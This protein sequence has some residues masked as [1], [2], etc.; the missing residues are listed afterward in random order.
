MIQKRHYYNNDNNNSNNNNNNY[1]NNNNNNSL[2][3]MLA[4]QHATQSEIIC[5]Y[6]EKQKVRPVPHNM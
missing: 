6:K 5:S 4:R 3:G 1:N 2:F